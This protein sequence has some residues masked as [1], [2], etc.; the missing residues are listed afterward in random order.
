MSRQGSISAAVPL[1]FFSL[2]LGPAGPAEPGT[3]KPVKVFLG[4]VCS[5]APPHPYLVFC[6]ATTKSS[7][8]M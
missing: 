3:L 7:S 4:A 1:V 2:V 6:G 5:F 8:C